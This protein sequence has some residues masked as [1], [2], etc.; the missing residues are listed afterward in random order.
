MSEEGAMDRFL[1]QMRGESVDSEGVF[2]VD[3]QKAREKMARFQLGHR[4]H[5]LLKIIQAGVLNAERIVITS[6]TRAFVVELQGWDH[7]NVSLERIGQSLCSL[8]DSAPEDAGGCLA[9]G[10]N[11]ALEASGKKSVRVSAS[12]QG[13]SV[14]RTVTLGESLE[15]SEDDSGETAQVSRLEISIESP[16]HPLEE[17]ADTL[18]QRCRFSPIPIIFQGEELGPPELPASS[19]KHLGEFFQENSFLGEFRLGRITTP[20]ASLSSTAS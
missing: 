15:W 20:K 13:E 18:A 11:A 7:G 3:F 10:L 5:Y 14:R 19:G 12:V 9:V 6:T 2:T 8:F 16:S 1:D 4:T 17:V